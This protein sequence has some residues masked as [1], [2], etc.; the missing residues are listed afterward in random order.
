MRRSQVSKNI[1]KA[2]TM[3]LSSSS[4]ALIGRHWLF[5]FCRLYNDVLGIEVLILRLETLTGIFK[6]YSVGCLNDVLKTNLESP[7]LFVRESYVSWI[8]SNQEMSSRYAS[9][10][11]LRNLNRKQMLFLLK[12]TN[13]EQAPVLKRYNAKTST[14]FH[15]WCDEIGYKI[16]YFALCFSVLIKQLT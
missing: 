7:T 15:Q 9:T 14:I 5:P 2:I 1:C 3:Y 6:M 16:P 4:L 12:Y 13:L 10:I 8:L 11:S